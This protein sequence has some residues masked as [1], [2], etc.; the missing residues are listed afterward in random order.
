MKK[1]LLVI[2]LMCILVTGCSSSKENSNSNKSSKEDYVVLKAEKAE[3]DLNGNI[4]ID[5]NSVTKKVSYINYSVDGVEIGFIV[6]KGT[7]GKVRIAF[8]TC[9][10]CSPSPNAYFLQ[11]GQYI[12]CQNC[13]NRF[14]I[15]E[16]GEESGGCNPTPVEEKI[17]EADKVIIDSGY[18]KTLKEKFENWNGPKIN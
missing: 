8:N 16:I 9:Q 2:L 14:H 7:D 1:L 12:E 6:V 5:K 11:K 3:L 15:D 18:V 4:V 17:D 10:A 13:K